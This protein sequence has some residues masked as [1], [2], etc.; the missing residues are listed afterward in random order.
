MTES[1]LQE[2]F[3]RIHYTPKDSETEEEILKNLHRNHAFHIPF[4]N[5]DVYRKMTVS[6]DEDALFEK[7]VRQ[8]RGGYCFE[9]NGL[10]YF[11]LLSM[12]YTVHSV[13]A[14]IGGKD[15]PFGGLTHRMNVVF[16]SNGTKWAADV[17]YGGDGLIE[18]VLISET[19]TV[20]FGRTYR[21]IRKEDDLM[22]YHLQVLSDGEF[23]NQFCFNEEPN[24]QKDFEI[25][26]F[27]TNCHPDSGFRQRVMCTLPTPE[28]RISISD[29]RLRVVRNGEISDTFFPPES[30]KDILSAHF[31]IHI[32]I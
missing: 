18:P 3:A 2:Y 25:C 28:G 21:V 23:V 6:L 26:N 1:Q 11:V 16:L 30:L 17:G 9:M 13:L 7:L 19:P 20:S 27:Y 4:E 24:Q 10:F 14:R 22:K 15:R 31:D 5:M 32:D 8:K 12:G 29:D